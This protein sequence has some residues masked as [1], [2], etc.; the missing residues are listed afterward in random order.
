M[1]V[2]MIQ[3]GDVRLIMV[4]NLCMYLGALLRYFYLFCGDG[5]RQ[6][7]RHLAATRNNK[8]GAEKTRLYLNKHFH[9]TCSIVPSACT[10]L[11]SRC[12]VTRL[13]QATQITRSRLS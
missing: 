1:N 9:L 10:T 6:A 13:G 4:R 12:P 2:G 7:L 8:L 3:R 5:S 11:G